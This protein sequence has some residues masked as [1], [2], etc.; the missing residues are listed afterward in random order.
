VGAIHAIVPLLVEPLAAPVAVEEGSDAE[1]PQAASRALA[2]MTAS[3][4]VVRRG[5]REVIVVALRKEWD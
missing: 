4:G 3:R 1:E 2:A 5:V